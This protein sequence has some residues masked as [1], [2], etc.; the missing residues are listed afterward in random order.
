MVL[1]KDEVET[2]GANLS[3]LLYRQYFRSE[4]LKLHPGHRLTSGGP[5]HSSHIRISWHYEDHKDS[6]L[7]CIFVVGN[8]SMDLQNVYRLR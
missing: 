2:E 4:D 6:V 1:Y 7:I 5:N 3:S 8:I